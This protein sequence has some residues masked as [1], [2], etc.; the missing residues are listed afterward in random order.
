[1]ASN[2]IR[3]TGL[4]SGLDTESLV[5]A[6]LL[7]QQNKIDKQVRKQQLY[8]WKQDAWKEMN[9]K[10]NTFKENYVDKLKMQSTF[11]K[12]KA[13][14]SNA[15]AVSVSDTSNLG[16]G[17]H[18]VEIKQLA[19]SAYMMTKGATASVKP[20][21]ESTTLRELGIDRDTTLD[22]GGTEVTITADSTITDLSS[23]LR[24]KG[25]DVSLNSNNQLTFKNTN[26]AGSDSI[27]IKVVND[28]ES[29][30][31]SKLGMTSGLTMTLEAQ[32]ASTGS[33][34]RE[35]ELS[36]NTQLGNLLDSNGQPLITS[37]LNLTV[38]GENV[39]LSTGDTISSMISKMKAADGNLSVNFDSGLNQF[40]VNSTTTGA[41]SKTQIT[42]ANAEAN[43]LLNALGIV[44]TS[45]EDTTTGKNALYSYNGMGNVTV[46]GKNYFE[47]SSNTV[48]INGLEMTL[49]EV[50]TEPVTIQGTTNTDELVSFMK[51]FVSE[52][53]ALL[54][55]INTK[56]TTKTSSEYEP[57]TDEEKEAT[58][59]S[60]VEKIEKYI[61]DGLFYRDSDLM[62]LRDSLRDTMSGVVTGN[63]KY[64]TLHSI[65]LTTG[66][67][68]EQGK[69]TFDEETF[70]KAIEE[71]PQDVINI[72]AGSGNS[73]EAVKEY[74]KKNNITDEV[75]AQNAYN[76]L[77]YKD[78]QKYLESSKGIFNRISTNLSTLSKS[79]EYKSYGSYYNDKLL[80]SD[81]TDIA[82]LI[83][84]LNQAYTTKETALYKKMT[85]MEKTISQLNSQQSYLTSMMSV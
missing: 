5:K 64:K 79:S 39:T 48:K 62:Q 67:W 1:M 56:L 27:E 82:D 81:L 16:N 63:T 3:F 31:F 57:L 72:F 54:D 76:A 85:A 2:T 65:G 11:I 52:Y 26:A 19:T 21:E 7:T 35:T 20:I 43:A 42:G 45:T 84:K 37:T 9:N 4:A 13:T 66:D 60:N 40:F 44:H 71:N 22:I 23:Q 59:E 24:D 15:N 75:E 70:I 8:T 30:F 47:S 73:D 83:Y 12:T 50:T 51:E 46:D 58:S 33:K 28:D 25:I 38:N 14:V 55:D 41:D 49:K 68:R 29:Q 10:I 74:M 77:S 17:V 36:S 18:K 61:K 78:K 53:N 69:L 34:L 80:K 32:Q 6:M